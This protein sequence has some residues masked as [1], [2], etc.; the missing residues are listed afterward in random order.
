MSEL[1]EKLSIWATQLEQVIKEAESPKIS[2]PLSKLK[3]AANQ[4][5]RAWG[6]SWLG[7]QSR[8][9]YSNFSPPPPG[10][11]FS[12]EWGFMETCIEDTTGE[13]V[14]YTFDGVR[15]TIFSSAGVTSLVAL[16]KFANHAKEVFENAREEFLSVVTVSLENESDP[17]LA[18]L[19]GQA[20][21]LKLTNKFDFAKAIQPKG[22]FMSRDSLAVTQ[23]MQ[24]PPHLSVLAEVCALKNPTQQCEKLAKIIRRAASHLE[25]KEHRGQAKQRI[26][27]DVFIGHGRSVVWKDLKDF[28]QDR[29]DLPWDEFNRVPVAGIANIARLSEMLDSAAIAFVILTAEDEQFDAKMHPRMNV[30]H[31]AGLFQGKL[32]FTKAIVLLEEGCEEFSNIQGLGQIR[33]P[34]GNIKAAFEELRRVLEREKLIEP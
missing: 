29:L 5:G 15:D 1:A 7:Y 28:I 4:V 8:V 14:E 24:T 17:F 3:D 16:E 22:S 27:T 30:V 13:W 21:D 18:R 32:G 12:S 11:H 33:F 2:D 20:E 25:T 34:K 26:G 10:A 23:G 6:G 19:K 31:E 9:Y